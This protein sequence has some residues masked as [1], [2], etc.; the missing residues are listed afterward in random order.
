MEIM[1]LF[2]IY[3]ENDLIDIK[4]EKVCKNLFHAKEIEYSDIAKEKLIRF[5]K[6]FPTYPL[7]I[8]KTQYS[9]SDDKNLLGYPK[10]TTI[11]IRDLKV[12]NGAEF[13]VVYLGD[14]MTMPGLPKIPAAN[15]IDIDQNG[16]IINIF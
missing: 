4:I 6:H 3:E 5:Q 8:A 13:I 12:S 15:Q 11:H 16:E 10:N 2:K 1:L 14:I 7:C 9:I